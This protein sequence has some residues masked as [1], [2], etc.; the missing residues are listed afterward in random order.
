[1]NIL[2]RS[3]G[4]IASRIRNLR[5]RFS[6][7][8]LDGYCWLRAIEVPRHPSAIHLG[9]SVALDKGVVLLVSGNIRAEPIIHIGDR[10]YINRHVILD[11]SFSL[12]VGSDC[13]IGPFSYLTDHDHGPEEKREDL[14]ESPTIIEDGVWIGAH[15]TVLKGV[16]IGRGAVV[17]AGSVVTR[18]VP[19]GATVA[20]NPARLLE[21]RSG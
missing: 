12:R 3:V 13:M 19:Q 10:T 2:A 18:D 6:G 21:R 8:K 5:F 9:Q 16:R 7:M 15:V 20:G 4:G 1:M 11:G 17:G 14:V